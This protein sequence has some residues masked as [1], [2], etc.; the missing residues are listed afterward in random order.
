MFLFLHLPPAQAQ[1]SQQRGKSIYRLQCASLQ[2]RGPHPAC[3]WGR[4]RGRG[5]WSRLLLNKGRPGATDPLEHTP[6]L[7]PAPGPAPSQPLGGSRPF[8]GSAGWGWAWRVQRASPCGLPALCPSMWLLLQGAE[9]PVTEWPRS[10][11][12]RVTSELSFHLWST[13]QHGLTQAGPSMGHGRGTWAPGTCGQPPPPA[14]P[15]GLQACPHI[16]PEEPPRGLPQSALQTCLGPPPR[17]PGPRRGATEAV[18]SPSQGPHPHSPQNRPVAPGGW[19]SF[20]MARTV[21]LVRPHH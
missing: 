1:S 13:P 19:S 10:S 21:Y 3:A 7:P 8:G 15:G 11:R 9:A 20:L 17:S 18:G 6:V 2:G 5:G 14:L 12:V 4:G 16:A